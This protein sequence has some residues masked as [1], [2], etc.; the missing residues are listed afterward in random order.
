[1]K[2]IDIACRCGEVRLEVTGDPIAQM[3]CHCEGCQA[4]HGGAYV[5]EG[6][7]PPAP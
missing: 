7:I 4:V 1:M 5:P 2:T 6:S 3:D